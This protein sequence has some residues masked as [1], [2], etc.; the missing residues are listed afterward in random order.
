VRPFAYAKAGDASAAV[1]AAADGATFIAGGTNLVDLMK[2][3]VATPSAVV[4]VRRLSRDVT[5]DGDSL[6][7][8]AGVTNSEL[9][10][11]PLVAERYPLLAD[12]VK[13]GASGQLR[14]MAT[15]G[16]NLLQRTR[17]P[18]F[19]DVS[20]PCNKREPGSG[21]PAIA[22]AHRELAIIGGSSS[23][24]ATH[25]SDMAVALTALDAHVHVTGPDGDRKLT[26][27]E[28]YRLPGD[29]PSRDTNLGPADLITAVELPPPPPGEHVY[30][31]VRDRRS[32]AFGLVSVATVI[33]VGDGVVRTCRIAFG[34]IAPKPWR[35]RGAE[36]VLIGREPTAE[37]AAAAADAELGA[38]QPLPENEFKVRL[39]KS[40][41]VEVLS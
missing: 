30:R 18:Y 14:N 27:D 35:A 11:H 16:G 33:D 10:S 41:L 13:A 37:T 40:L 7:V 9:A 19:Q 23:C 38:A 28:L 2:L 25:P 1:A 12:A 15:V 20:K 8:G 22:G 4:D 26:L 32:F 17:C 31:K 21:C 39:A 29:D 6:V 5:T 24:V 34:Q 36:A 3:G